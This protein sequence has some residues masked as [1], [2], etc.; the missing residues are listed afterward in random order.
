MWRGFVMYFSI[1]TLSSL[2]DFNDSLL[3]D[4]RASR[5]SYFLLTILIPFPPPPETAL[6]KT[7]HPICSACSN[8]YLASWF[9]WWYPGTTGTFAAVIIFLLSLLLPIETIADGG[10]PINLTPLLTHYSANFAFSDKNPKP[11]W[12]ASQPD[13]NATSKIFLELR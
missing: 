13:S 12:R 6:I 5:N 11:G 2:N 10:G 1:K 3:Q 7:G 9:Y 4:S 8:K